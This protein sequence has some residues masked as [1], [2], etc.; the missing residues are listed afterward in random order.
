MLEQQTTSLEN[1][2]D[3]GINTAVDNFNKNLPINY[4]FD[5]DK[6]IS[7]VSVTIRNEWEG[8]A[9]RNEVPVEITSVFI[10]AITTILLL[11]IQ[12]NNRIQEQEL[13]PLFISIWEIF[14]QW[15]TPS[16]PKK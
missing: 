2:V 12:N 7:E 6:T 16:T 4:S 3:D 15:L 1:S 9:H 5:K 14:K 10:E 8:F 13:Q 11:R